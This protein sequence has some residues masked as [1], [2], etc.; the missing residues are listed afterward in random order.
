[1]AKQKIT[2]RVKKDLPVVETLKLRNGR[3]SALRIAKNEAQMMESDERR[4]KAMELRFKQHMP[5]RD[6]ARE[7]DCSVSDAYNLANSA[8][9]KLIE[10]IAEMQVQIKSDALND[11]DRQLQILAPFIFDPTV[12]I[13][14]FNEK[15]DPIP[16]P[17]FDAMLKAILASVKLRELQAKIIGILT[18]A[19]APSEG[20]GEKTI[21]DGVIMGI[22]KVFYEQ[23]TE[24]KAN[25]KELAA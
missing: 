9:V 11:I 10:N 2:L 13:V 18:P 12:N 25:V 6:I 19:K 15:G 23:T 21:T 17:K 4:L 24:K 14:S 7:L 8:W 16:F 3:N 5:Y 1:M 22:A 20:L